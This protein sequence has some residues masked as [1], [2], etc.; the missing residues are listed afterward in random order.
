MFH[1][2]ALAALAA[3]V[4]VAA[5]A[6]PSFAAD[7]RTASTALHVSATVLPLCQD[8]K[9]LDGSRTTVC[10]NVQTITAPAGATAIGSPYSAEPDGSAPLKQVSPS[11]SQATVIYL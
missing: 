3:A 2:T 6:A 9:R 7:K 11:G 8:F 5:T 10:N 4:I 1:K